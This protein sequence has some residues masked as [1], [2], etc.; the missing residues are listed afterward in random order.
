MVKSRWGIL[1]GTFDPVHYG[2]L[3]LAEGARE[4]LSLDRVLFVPAGDPPHKLNEPH[5]APVHRLKMLELA[6]A[7]NPH[8]FL[9]RMDLDR[10]GPHYSSDMLELVQQDAGPTVELYF[11]MGLDSLNGLL[12][13]HEPARLLDICRLVVANRPGYDVDMQK[14][15]AALPGLEE[16]LEWITIPMVEIAG[17]DLR[18]RVRAG[19]SIRY[20]V[21]EPV[22]AYIQQLGL[23]PE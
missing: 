22:R 23:Y 1:G 3:L 4:M 17:V 21:P 10:P 15:T 13:W 9:S 19:R 18:R 6:L 8:F 11:L 2:H 5:T 14:M 16:R 20:Q 12:S 7:D